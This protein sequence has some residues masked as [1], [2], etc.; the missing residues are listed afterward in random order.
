MKECTV[1]HWCMC[2]THL[3]KRLLYIVEGFYWPISIIIASVG[4]CA[5]RVQNKTEKKKTTEHMRPVVSAFQSIF[6]Q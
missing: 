2:V 1:I 5:R 4:F 3:T 6:S